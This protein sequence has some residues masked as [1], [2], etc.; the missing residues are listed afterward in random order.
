MQEFDFYR[1]TNGHQFWSPASG[2]VDDP[3][4]TELI[5][6]TI[7]SDL[8]EGGRFI[9]VMFTN[10]YACSCGASWDDEWTCACD[11]ECPGCGADISPEDST[12]HHEELDAIP[13]PPAPCGVFDPSHPAVLAFVNEAVGMPDLPKLEIGTINNVT[14]TETTALK[15]V[16]V[17]GNHGT[18][19]VDHDTGKVL[20]YEA[21]EDAAYRDIVSVDLDEWRAFWG[22][23]ELDQHIDILDVDAL[24]DTGEII[25]AEEDWRCEA[26]PNGIDQPMATR[27]HHPRCV[28]RAGQRFLCT[29]EDVIN[30]VI[31]GR[32]DPPEL[33]KAPSKVDALWETIVEAAAHR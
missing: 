21:E 1:I 2:W 7:G 23:A 6:S 13:C 4:E 22:Q 17:S 28:F 18:L 20:S 3:D 31:P 9:G 5:D 15:T 19:T 24:T 30:Q 10:H 32:L 8:P 29:C 11:D 26:I 16:E 25:K 27:P 14:L 33:S 12:V